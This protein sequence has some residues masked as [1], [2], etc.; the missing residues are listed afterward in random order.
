MTT[1]LEWTDRG[2]IQTATG[3]LGTYVALLPRAGLPGRAYLFAPGVSLC[4]V[5]RDRA[6]RFQT[7]HNPQR[8]AQAWE[9]GLDAFTDQASEKAE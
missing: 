9:N 8:R 1:Q 5:N 2:A 6:V 7:T 4:P 3:T